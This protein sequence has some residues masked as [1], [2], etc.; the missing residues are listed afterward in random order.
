MEIGLVKKIDIDHEMQQSYLDYAMSV[1]ASRA[2]PDARDGLK[3]VQRRILYAMYDLGIRPGS[4][5]KKSARIVGEVLGK[6]H[7]HGDVAVYDAMAR[8]AQDFSMR[9]LAVDGQGNF[10]SVDGDPP[11]AMRYTEA[12]MTQYSMEM[13]SQIEKDTVNFIRNF[14][15][16]LVE[17]E[18]MPAAVPNL[19]LNGASGI[20][21][22]MSTNIPPHNFEELI[23]AMIYLLDNWE[24]MDDIA[25]SDLLE[26]VKGPDFPTGGLILQEGDKND[27]LTAYSTGKGRVLVRGR[28]HLEEMTRGK[29]KIIITELPYQT[30]KAAL[31]EK[32]ADLVRE[33]KIEGI[34]DLRDESDKQGMRIVIELAKNAETD[35]I[36]LNLYQKT[37]LQ[38][39]FSITLLALVNGEPRLLNL[40]Q[41]LKVYLNHRFDV[42]KRRSRFELN[43]AKERAHILEGLRV[44]IKH[45]DEI[46]ELIKKSQDVTDAQGKLIKRYKL[47]QLQAQAI[48]DMPLK[49]I[50]SLERKKID[51][52]YKELQDTIK[53]LEGILKSEKRMREL[54]KQDL[55]ELKT[56][57]SDSRRTQIV[58]LKEG[59]TSKM[60]LTSQAVMPVEEVY[61]GI[62]SDG[63]IGRLSA[64]KGFKGSGKAIPQWLIKTDSHQ[65]AYIVSKSGRTAS[66]GVSSIPIVEK[67]EDGYPVNK[68]TP[69]EQNESVTD[70]FAIDSSDDLDNL[71]I[72]TLSKSGMIKK[73]SCS[74]LPGPSSSMFTLSKANENDE[75]IKCVLTNDEEQIVLLTA[76]GMIIR[77][78][79]DGVRPMGLVAAGVNGI[80]LKNKDYLLTG[81]VA[82]QDQTIFVVSNNCQAWRVAL[83]DV[84]IQGRYGQ[85]VIFCKLKPGQILRGGLLEQNKQSVFCHFKKMTSKAIKLDSI[86]ITKRSALG[87]IL[88]ELKPDDEVTGITGEINFLNTGKENEKRKPRK[89]KEIKPG[90]REKGNKISPTKGDVVEKKAGKSRLIKTAKPKVEKAEV[91]K[92]STNKVKAEQ[93]TLSYGNTENRAKPGK[94]K[95]TVKK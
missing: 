88:F 85:G 93:L 74:E 22:G 11:A 80:K 68:V 10:G 7:P 51:L 86:A 38:S 77:F 6:Y 40:K 39:T 84:P 3:P 37:P 56:K 60:V 94:P 14:D 32:I 62:T 72:T 21:V 5:Y 48:L 34:A 24:K 61:V 20:A 19:L 91:K 2:L 41:A 76:L 65:T 4:D 15:E 54:E 64:E 29:T 8:M 46:I 31:I 26:Y 18:V 87:K 49:R 35:K 42:I 13:L 79:L 59:T 63:L 44:A 16:T 28:V 70:I 89:T 90:V 9:Y 45:L 55:L 47:T 43:K 25:V 57:Y 67:F 23:N 52:E 12:R 53:Y 81:G 58:S 50:S 73:S 82:N 69:F 33:N 17:P 75:I 27:I 36:L 66:V 1:I 30:N 78:S 71:Y 95:K 92:R 83:S